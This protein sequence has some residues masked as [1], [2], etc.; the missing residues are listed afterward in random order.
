MPVIRDLSATR[1]AMIYA[2]FKERMPGGQ[3]AMPDDPRLTIPVL[4]GTQ[5]GQAGGV[6]MSPG[7][8]W[9]G[10]R[11]ATKSPPRL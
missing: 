9:S 11:D 2:W 7:C 6:P 4:L 5:S 10:S 1:R 3:G 8:S